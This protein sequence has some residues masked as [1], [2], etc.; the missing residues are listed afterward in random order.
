MGKALKEGA[1]EVRLVNRTRQT[2]I[3]LATR[4]TPDDGRTL[5]VEDW[6]R[7]AA[8][9]AGAGLLVNTTSLGMTGQPPLELDLAAL[10]RQALVNDVVYVPLRTDL[11]SRA[12]ARGNPTVD[13]LGMLLHQGRPGCA[14]W[15]GG[16]RPAVSPALRKAVAGDLGA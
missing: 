5:V 13:G 4:F 12:R 10:P 11:L 14:A 16:A 8:A 6:S 1:P 15:F 3:E 9:L 7:R 2:A